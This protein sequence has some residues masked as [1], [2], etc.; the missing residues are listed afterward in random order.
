M[1]KGHQAERHQGRLNV[2]RVNFLVIVTDQHRADYLGCY[3]H[4][5]L[6][7]PHIDSL[8]QRGSRFERFHVASP[9]CMP[10]RASLLTG[11][12]PSA[13]GLRD[14]GNI[15]SW[16]ANT[17]VDVLR[18]AGFRTVHLGKSH[19][20]PM[21]S[22]PAESRIDEAALG[23]IHEA[24]KDDGGDYTQEQPHHYRSA[25]RYPARTPFYGYDD[26]DFVTQHGDQAGAHYLQWL[27]RQTPDA[28]KLRDRANQLPHDYVCPQAYRTPIPEEL[29]STSYIR[30]RAID[31]LAS[32]TGRDQP[33]FAFVSFPDPHHPFTP[34]GRYWDLYDPADFQVPLP[35]EAH[36]NPPPPILWSRRQMLNGRRA[37]QGPQDSFFASPREI[38]EA[39]ALTCGMIGMIDDAVGD[40]LAALKRSGHADHTVVIFTSDHGDYLGDYGMM[41]KGPLPLR[42]ITRVPFIWADP[43]R[44]AASVQTCLAST[45]DIAPTVLDR[46]GLKPYFGMQGVSLLPA[47]RGEAAARNSLLVEYQDSKT[48][49]GFPKPAFVRTLITE[50]HRYTVYKDQ[51][52]GELYDLR[53]D[54]DES[55]NRWADPAFASVRGGLTE[56]LL[57]ELMRA[58]DQSPRSRF[59]A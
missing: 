56:Q 1:G 33:F 13:H 31:F 28:D 49:Q 41:L 7:T 24:W 29:Y 44:R 23:L 17:F 54:P 4:P 20:Q 48:R 2:S 25:D 59:T 5:L 27:R 16:R 12:L 34:P 36:R 43:R 57:H 51:D 21:T 52:W 10:N 18:A 22:Q 47:L 14:N 8:A 53:Q 35:F 6:R 3:G 58:V 37:S 32:T 11:R 38:Q 19:I 9:V 55:H 39:M 15:L 42:S 45:L 40:V 26:V 46:A 30:D 50:D